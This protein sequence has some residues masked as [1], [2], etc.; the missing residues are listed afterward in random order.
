MEQRLRGRRRRSELVSGQFA[1]A[2]DAVSLERDPDLQSRLLGVVQD[3]Q[4]EAIL[5]RAAI[6]SGVR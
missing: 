1:F 6:R 2:G 4:F 5:D 3:D